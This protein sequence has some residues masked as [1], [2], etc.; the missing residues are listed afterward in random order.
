MFEHKKYNLHNVK[1]ILIFFFGKL[2][3]LSEKYGLSACRNI[4]KS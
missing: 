4:I 3:L 1:Y 2:K